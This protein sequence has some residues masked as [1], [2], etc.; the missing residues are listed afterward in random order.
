MGYILALVVILG[1]HRRRLPLLGDQSM[2]DGI[3]EAISAGLYGVIGIHS[4]EV[5]DGLVI[6]R[7]RCP[8]Q[9]DVLL[10]IRM[11]VQISQ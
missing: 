7:C 2:G 5:R 10:D 6:K 4:K 9:R 8:F 3:L 1:S 11:T